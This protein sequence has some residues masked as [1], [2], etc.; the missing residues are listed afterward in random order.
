MPGHPGYLGGIDIKGT[1]KENRNIQRKL[2]E[3]KRKDSYNM[4]CPSTS[5]L[6]FIQFDESSENE[7]L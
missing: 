1:I 3:W 5:A 4:N 7:S 6:S 2:N